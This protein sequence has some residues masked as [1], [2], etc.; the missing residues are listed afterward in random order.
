MAYVYPLHLCLHVLVEELRSDGAI[1]KPGPVLGLELLP[2]GATLP[3]GVVGEPV[4]AVEIAF[5]DSREI[6]LAT[7]GLN[8]PP[9]VE[10]YKLM[11]MELPEELHLAHGLDQ[12]HEELDD[13]IIQCLV[14]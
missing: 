3:S 12:V 8:R 5:P 7:W 4:T 13:I 2:E 6:D 10:Y 14:K 1:I 9:D 11:G